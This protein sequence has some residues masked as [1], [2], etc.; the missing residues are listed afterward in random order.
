MNLHP[1]RLAGY[2]AD[3]DGIALIAGDVLEAELI[4]VSLI[5]D[6]DSTKVLQTAADWIDGA[7]RRR[8]GMPLELRRDGGHRE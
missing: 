1:L 2:P 8:A 7:K 5:A 4:L 3:S 6:P